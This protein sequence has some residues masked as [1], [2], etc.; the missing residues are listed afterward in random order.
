LVSDGKLISE[1]EI[2]RNIDMYKILEPLV[3][4]G[5]MF[6]LPVSWMS[7]NLVLGLG[8]LLVGEGLSMSSYFKRMVLRVRNADIRIVR[9]FPPVD[10]Q[11]VDQEI[12]PYPPVDLDRLKPTVYLA[13]PH[14]MFCVGMK[15]LLGSPFI[16]PGSVVMFDSKLYNMSWGATWSARTLGHPSAPLTHKSV[17]GIMCSGQKNICVMPGGFVEA[18]GATETIEYISLDKITYYQKMCKRYGYRL[19]YLMIYGGSTFYRHHDVWRDARLQLAAL[20]IPSAVVTPTKVF[21][22]E[23]DVIAVRPFSIHLDA[24][25]SHISDQL[26]AVYASDT[27]TLE[28]EHRMT[29]KQLEIRSC[30]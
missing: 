25:V 5:S 23:A 20:D 7:G 22:G 10:I 11:P 3:S 18:A 14:G 9:E 21:G 2:K 26:K 27:V 30:L 8:T 1:Y 15:R 4:W 24:S 28:R 12:V 13:G 19:Q 29:M 6:I 17:S 16:P